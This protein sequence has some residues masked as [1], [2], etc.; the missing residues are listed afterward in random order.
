MSL[1]SDKF[2]SKKV[3][4]ICPMDKSYKLPF[5]DRSSI[6]QS[7]VELLHLDLWGQLLEISHGGY[8]F[9]LSIVDNHTKI[10][11]PLSSCLEYDI[12]RTIVNFKK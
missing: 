12:L 2:N 10:C 6:S 8:H 11:L 9:Y 3:C 4:H 5:L 1:V 7:L